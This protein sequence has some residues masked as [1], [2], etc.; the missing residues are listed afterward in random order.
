MALVCFSKK[1]HEDLQ[2]L[3]K[4]LKGV[5]KREKNVLIIVGTPLYVLNFPKR[6]RDLEFSC[7][8]GAVDKIWGLL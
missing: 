1:L 2:N 8:K 6:E 7:E 3:P 4:L 5:K